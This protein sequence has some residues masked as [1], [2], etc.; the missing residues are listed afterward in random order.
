MVTR[1]RA[2][3]CAGCHCVDERDELGAA[4][5]NVVNQDLRARQVQAPRVVVSRA[6]L[7]IAMYF[8]LFLCDCAAIRC[9]FE[10]GVSL[11]GWK[12]LAPNGVELGWLIL[13]IHFV[14]GLRNGAYSHIALE[15][16]NE[17]IRRALSAFMMATCAI[18]LLVLFQYAGP[19]VSRLAFGAAILC[20]LLFI[21]IARSLFMLCFLWG[22]TDGL[23]GR[24]VIIDGVDPGSVAA[25][26]NGDP[27]FDAGAAGIIP[28]L[29]DP[30]ALRTVAEVVAP[31]DRVIV[32]TTP[33]RQYA[34][35]MLLKAYN[36]TGE[37]LIEGRT[38]LGALAVDDYHGHDTVV[39]ARG[40]MSLPNRAKKRLSDLVISGVAL[41]VLAPLFLLVAI[42]IKLDSP[43]PVLFA[44][45]RVGRGNKWFRILKFRSMLVEQADQSGA[46][47]AA[48]DDDRITRVGRFI[49]RTSIDELPQLINVLMGT[50][51]IVGPRP[52]ALGSLAG[53]KPFWEVTER[54][55]LRHTLKPGITGL[56][57]V[58]GFRGAT[59]KQSDLEKRLQS[60]LEYINGWRMWRD[61][62]I[63]VGTLRV[64]VHP[65]AF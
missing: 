32:A 7:R 31:Y 20:T 47:S 45:T 60:D 1:N 35:A 55:W 24:L 38:M 6:A 50:M 59:D 21:I 61:V 8:A 49:R 63:M 16:A 9:G 29:A 39:V 53:D 17:S 11:R 2:T 33:D 40:A 44:Q 27:V 64:I 28:D 41:I 23:V 43:G 42:A 18:S 58:R 15:S 12:W 65:R 5:L 48:R 22:R 30:Q 34:W 37:I 54:Y 36:V 19:L 4:R 57:Q 10:I 52:H 3:G 25:Y 46:R 51:S 14:L 26:S 13:P 62:T 56:A